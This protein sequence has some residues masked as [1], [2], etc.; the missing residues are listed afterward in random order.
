VHP[1]ELS[2]REMNRKYEIDHD[3]FKKVDTREKTYLFGLIMTDGNIHRQHYS[4][5]FD[6]QARDR[7]LCEI[8][9]RYLGSNV[10]IRERSVK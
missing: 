4:L 6:L 5:R 3:F 8:A 2:I 9:R 1:N 7:E 10:P